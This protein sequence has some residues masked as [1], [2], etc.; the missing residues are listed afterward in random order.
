M[1]KRISVRLHLGLKIIQSLK[2]FKVVY[3]S[4]QELKFRMSTVVNVIQIIINNAVQLMLFN[5]SSAK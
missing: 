2:L 1:G 5:L 3:F 4:V